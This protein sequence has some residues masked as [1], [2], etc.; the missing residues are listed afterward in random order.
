L[1]VVV[2]TTGAP[3]PLATLEQLVNTLPDDFVFMV[4]PKSGHNNMSEFLDLVDSL[5]G[6][7]RAFIKMDIVPVDRFQ[8]AKARGYITACYFYSSTPEQTI[9]DRMPYVDL[10]GMN[11]DAGATPWDNLL[12]YGKPVWGHVVS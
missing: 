6:P 4:D 2:G 3:K 9:I 1:N 5:L 7:E 10:P 12:A 8:A 11:W